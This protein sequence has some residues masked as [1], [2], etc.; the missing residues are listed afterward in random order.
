MDRLTVKSYDRK[1]VI[2]I[3]LRGLLKYS[4]VGNV[5]GSYRKSNFLQNN[6]YFSINII[7]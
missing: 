3:Q 6:C 5:V 4:S 1:E 7:A 2:G